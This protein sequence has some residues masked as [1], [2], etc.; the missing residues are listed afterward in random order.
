MVG[1]IIDSGKIV[2]ELTGK[3]LE[4]YIVLN[5]VEG[6]TVNQELVREV[7]GDQVQV[8]AVDV[9]RLKELAAELYEQPEEQALALKSMLV[10]T[11]AVAATLTKGDLPVYLASGVVQPVA[12]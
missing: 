7:S 6:Y 9:W 3:H 2:K 10:Y 8:F 5:D 1:E 4:M 12:A 11:L